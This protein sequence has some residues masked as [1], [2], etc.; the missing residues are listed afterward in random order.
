MKYP[1][2]GSKETQDGNTVVVFF[3][4]PNRGA[5][6]FSDNDNVENEAFGYNGS[7]TENEYTFYPD[8]L[9]VRLHN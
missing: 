7:I 6:V 5:V 4:S 1:Y 8:G 2:L 9:C 3:T